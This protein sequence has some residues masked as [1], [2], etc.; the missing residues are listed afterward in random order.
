MVVCRW[1]KRYLVLEP[2]G[3][4]RLFR[5]KADASVAASDANKT[6]ELDAVSSR[7]AVDLHEPLSL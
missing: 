1:K 3:R 5:D 7:Q 4:L 2:G 6:L